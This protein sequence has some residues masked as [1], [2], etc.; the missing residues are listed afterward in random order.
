MP[1]TWKMLWARPWISLP[2]ID[3]GSELGTPSPVSSRLNC[4]SLG[5]GSSWPGSI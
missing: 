4:I 3:E 5:L 1:P 2:P